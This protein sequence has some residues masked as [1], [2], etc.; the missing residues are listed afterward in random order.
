MWVACRSRLVCAR[1]LRM[2]VAWRMCVR[3]QTA[4]NARLAVTA[5]NLQQTPQSQRI[6]PFLMKNLTRR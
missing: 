5:T 1:S 2:V 3:M 6:R 4:A